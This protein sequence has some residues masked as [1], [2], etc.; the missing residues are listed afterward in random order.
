MPWEASIPLSTAAKLIPMIAEKSLSSAIQVVLVVQAEA[1]YLYGSKEYSFSISELD[2]EQLPA[3]IFYLLC[4]PR[5][6]RML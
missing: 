4:F 1:Q 5:S 3:W 6:W 2:G